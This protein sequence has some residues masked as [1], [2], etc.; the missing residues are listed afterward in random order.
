M[1][2]GWQPACCPPRPLPA[3]D[4]SAPTCFQ[5]PVPA[6]FWCAL[7]VPLSPTHLIPQLVV[8]GQGETQSQAELHSGHVHFSPF[9]R[10]KVRPKT[11]AG[12]AKQQGSSGSGGGGGDG[13]SG[14]TAP[15][16]RGIGNLASLRQQLAEKEK[17]EA[18]ALE[19]QRREQQRQA[20]LR[21]AQQQQQRPQ[22]GA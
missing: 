9:S 18:Q 3:S 15:A 2:S 19:T 7:T 21:Q 16:G 4:F 8:D 10:I 13:G 11:L 5:I 12:G 22:P 1:R 6:H 17:E 14:R 20:R